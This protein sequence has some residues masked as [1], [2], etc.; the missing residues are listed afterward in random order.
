MQ[1]VTSLQ[2]M[3]FFWLCVVMCI[4]LKMHLHPWKKMATHHTTHLYLLCIVWMFSC[5]LPLEK[6]VCKWLFLAYLS[7]HFNFSPV[8]VCNLSNY[9]FDSTCGSNLKIWHALRVFNVNIS[10][11]TQYVSNNKIIDELKSFIYLAFY[12][13][14]FKFL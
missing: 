14:F 7:S 2:T 3:Y 13:T 10:Q 1:F 5:Q 9:N 12:E 11:L 6:I 8:I 4:D